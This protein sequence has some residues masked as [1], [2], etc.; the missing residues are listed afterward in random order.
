MGLKLDTTEEAYLRPS[1]T[2]TMKFFA[3]IMSFSRQRLHNCRVEVIRKTLTQC[4]Y[5]K[6]N[7]LGNKLVDNFDVP[8]FPRWKLM[9]LKIHPKKN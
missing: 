4:L 8:S 6:H 2:S 3:K 5:G 9:Y 1:Q 7:I